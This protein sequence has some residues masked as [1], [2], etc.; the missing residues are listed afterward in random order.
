M[1]IMK[2]LLWIIIK[3]LKKQFSK[4]IY[5]GTKSGYQFQTQLI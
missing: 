4:I 2:E 5:W 3:K 1:L